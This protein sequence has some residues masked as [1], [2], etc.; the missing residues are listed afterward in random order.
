MN[1]QD[2]VAP[3]AVV[4]EGG[5]WTRGRVLER[6]AAL[7]APATG[8]AAAALLSALNEREALGT[9]GFGGGTAVPHGRLA[10]L[11]G[12]H[13]ALLLLAAPL[14][15]GAVDAQPVDLVVALV[16]P[17]AAGAE[18]LKLLARVSRALRDGAFVAKMR[19]ATD[20]GALWAMLDDAP[21]RQA[22]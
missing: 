22:A 15:W 20:A 7:L 4:L 21:L 12:F 13:G 9:T 11:D 8:L 3:G 16:G 2:V 14:D 19:G 6:A 17:E 5:L 18:H 10:G 1:L